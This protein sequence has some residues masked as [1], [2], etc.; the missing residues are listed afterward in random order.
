MF[1]KISVPLDFLVKWPSTP[2]YGRNFS[3]LFKTKPFIHGSQKSLIYPSELYYT[4]KNHRLA[5]FLPMSKPKYHCFS[6]SLTQTQLNNCTETI[7]NQMVESF[8]KKS[9][10]TWSF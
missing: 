4:L 8:V 5:K 9:S 10:L 1:V 7:T 3:K 2:H 6:V